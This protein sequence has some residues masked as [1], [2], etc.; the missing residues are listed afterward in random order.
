ML[1]SKPTPTPMVQSSDLMHKSPCNES[2]SKLI[3][4]V[5][6]REVIIYLLFLAVRTRPDISVAVSILS[7]HVQCPRPCHWKGIKHVLHYLKGTV[8]KGLTYNVADPSP[9]LK[10]C[11]D[12]DWETDPEDR[13]SRSGVVCF[14]GRNLV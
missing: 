3:V 11:C 4:G 6:Y 7:K 9:V 14:L 13:Y 2:D 10:I 12:A 8:S 1:E 5:A